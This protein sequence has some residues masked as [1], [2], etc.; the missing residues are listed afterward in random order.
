MALE[1]DAR[2]EPML[3]LNPVAATDSSGILSLAAALQ[4]GN[5]SIL[6]WDEAQIKA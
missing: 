2:P 4:I 5:A 1:S 6:G 3:I